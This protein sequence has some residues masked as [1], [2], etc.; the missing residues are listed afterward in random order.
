[1]MAEGR[2]TLLYVKASGAREK[3]TYVPREVWAGYRDDLYSGR[4]DWKVVW[5][6]ANPPVTSQHLLLTDECTKLL[7]RR[8]KRKTK[9]SVLRSGDN[10]YN[11]IRIIMEVFLLLN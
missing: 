5:T 4:P 6:P 11:E 8:I 9:K 10:F 3:A 1:M 2:T 7:C